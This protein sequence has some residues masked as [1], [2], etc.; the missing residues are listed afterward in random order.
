[1]PSRQIFTYGG[2]RLRLEPGYRWRRWL[3]NPI[4][5]ESHNPSFR[6]RVERVRE[7]PDQERLL[8]GSAYSVADVEDRTLPIEIHTTDDV[9]HFEVLLVPNITVGQKVFLPLPEIMSSQGKVQIFLKLYLPSKEGESHELPSECLYSY[10][11]KLRLKPTSNGHRSGG[12]RCP[13][14]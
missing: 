6:M 9:R 12:G 1:M 13:S 7:R 2:L 8:E 3:H 10:L 11:A 4:Y 5:L 14:C